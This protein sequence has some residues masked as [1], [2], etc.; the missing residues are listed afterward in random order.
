VPWFAGQSD[1]LFN[2]EERKVIEL[3][4]VAQNTYHVTMDSSVSMYGMGWD[5]MGCKEQ[6][7]RDDFFYYL[8]FSDSFD[9]FFFFLVN[10]FILL[11]CYF[12]L[13]AW[14]TRWDWARPWRSLDSS[15]QTLRHR[16]RCDGCYYLI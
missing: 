4:D 16:V 9:F 11:I 8:L 7:V 14:R 3:Q 10:N 5:G 2:P 12:L 1:L 6:I 15:W 13:V